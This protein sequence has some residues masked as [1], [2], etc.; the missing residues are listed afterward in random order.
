MSISKRNQEQKGKNTIK[1]EVNR[2]Y[3]CDI[4]KTNIFKTWGREKTEKM[5][6]KTTFWHKVYAAQQHLVTSTIWTKTCIFEGERGALIGKLTMRM[7]R[8]N[9][10]S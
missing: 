1:R 9:S 8:E 4:C 2:P 7:A 10:I 5:L 6:I 3:S